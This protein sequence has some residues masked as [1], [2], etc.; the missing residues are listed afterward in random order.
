MSLMMKVRQY[1]D[2]DLRSVAHLFVD[3]VRS[4]EDR[5]YNESQRAAWAPQPI[6]LEIWQ[7]RLSVL[8]TLVAEE[9]GH[10]VGFISFESNGHI[11]FLYTHP[12]CER[13]GVASALYRQVESRLVSAGICEIFT[14]AS[15]VARSFFEKQGFKTIEEQ[16]VSLRGVAFLRFSMRKSIL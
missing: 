1:R 11:E 4:V 13:R 12:A 8:Q 16:R 10:L 2:S 5:F 6:D 9:G 3:S 7:R 14:E 15:L